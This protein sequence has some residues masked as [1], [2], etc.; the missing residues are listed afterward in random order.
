MKPEPIVVVIEYTAQPGK[1][2]VAHGELARLIATVQASERDCLRISL[3]RNLDQRERM[4]L[5]E[6]WTSREAFLGPHL[7]TPYLQEFIAGAS[8]FLAQPPD[9]SFWATSDRAD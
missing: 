9:V 1:A 8:R 2:D 6:R 3:H 5:Y 4:F 7:Q